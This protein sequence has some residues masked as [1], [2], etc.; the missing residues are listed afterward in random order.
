MA[1]LADFDFEVKYRPRQHN[2]ALSRQPLAGEPANPE[3]V[4]YDDRVTICIVVNKGTP[5]DPE[6]FT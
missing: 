5:L 1:Q 3:D 6:L 4:E 2:D